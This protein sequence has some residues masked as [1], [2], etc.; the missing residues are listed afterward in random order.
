VPGQPF[1]PAIVDVHRA[2]QDRIKV[3]SLPGQDRRA[4]G[5]ARVDIDAALV[6]HM[7]H[8]RPDDSAG[9]TDP[10]TGERKFP[11]AVLVVYANEPKRWFEYAEPAK[12][13]ELDGIA[14][15]PG[16]EQSVAT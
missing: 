4:A 11:N 5:R 10:Q 3:R 13:S 9:L 2:D 8:M 7:H 6:T 15:R 14:V 12:A 16:W 1:R